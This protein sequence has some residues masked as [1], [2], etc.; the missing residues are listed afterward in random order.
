MIKIIKSKIDLCTGC[1]RCARECPMEMANITY[2]DENG[3]I[4][5]KVD[6]AMCIACGR[7]I[8]ACK[9]NARYYEDDTAQFFAD[10]SKGVPISLMVA[11]SIKTNIPNFKN[12]FTYLKQHGVNKIYDVS[13]GADICVWAHVKH[14]EKTKSLHMITQPCPPIVTYCEIYNHDLLKS[15]SPIHSPMSCTSIYMKKYQG[16]NDNIAALSPCIAKTNEFKD[17]K[18]AKYNITFIKLAEYLKKNNIVLPKEET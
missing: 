6:Y 14:I 11:P 18:H 16:I 12:L 1:N 17:T 5:V 4:K 2:Q 7:C 10:L 9:H 15:L 3:N 8:S 13:I